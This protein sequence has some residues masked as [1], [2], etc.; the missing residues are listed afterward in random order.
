MNRSQSKI[1]YMQQSNLLLEQRRIRLMEQPSGDTPTTTT[2]KT[3]LIDTGLKID[4][5]NR[6]ITSTNIPL[7]KEMNLIVI[8][9]FCDMKNRNPEKM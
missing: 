2:V 9:A 5:T 4:C 7:T 6:V 1:R 3:G 8:G